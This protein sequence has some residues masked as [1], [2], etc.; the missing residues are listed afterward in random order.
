[1][2]PDSSSLA[3]VCNANASDPLAGSERQKDPS[4]GFGQSVSTTSTFMKTDGAHR[5]GCETGQEASLDVVVSVQTKRR[6]YER[7]VNV[8]HHRNR[9]IHFCEFYAVEIARSDAGLPTR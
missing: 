9:G 4:Y 8:T 6:V 3:V 7:V 1:M 2:L 5:I